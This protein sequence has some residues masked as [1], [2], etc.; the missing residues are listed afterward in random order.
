MPYNNEVIYD[1]AELFKVFGDPTRTKILC[2]LFDRE[3]SVT[4]LIEAV[5]MTQSAV[6]HQLRILRQSRLVLVR[7]DGRS[8]F[9]SIGDNHI[10]R[11][12]ALALEHALELQQARN[13]GKPNL[14]VP[15]QTPQTFEKV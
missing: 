5:G 15:P 10:K 4:D 11:L 14:G 12:F 9:Y 2:A 13:H 8:A 7:R 1:V 6:S 3:M